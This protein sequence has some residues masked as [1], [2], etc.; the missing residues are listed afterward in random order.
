MEG[1]ME[2]FK[3]FIVEAAY[4]LLNVPEGHKCA[5]LHEHC[6]RIEI[7]VRVPVEKEVN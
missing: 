2:I 3:E 7:H 5:R 4:R 6:F 1:S